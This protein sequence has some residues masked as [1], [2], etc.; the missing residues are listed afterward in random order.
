ME[1]GVQCGSDSMEM[2]QCKE[3]V[4]LFQMD[5]TKSLDSVSARMIAACCFQIPLPQIFSPLLN[6]WEML[7]A[8][9]TQLF[10]LGMRISANGTCETS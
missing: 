1:V 5:Q 9:L 4:I 8:T 6:C 2:I 10:F 3:V 7:N